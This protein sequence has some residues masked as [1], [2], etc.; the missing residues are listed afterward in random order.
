MVE[1]E[2]TLIH[3]GLLQPQPESQD[4]TQA[5]AVVVFLA[6]ELMEQAVQVAVEL[7]QL[8][9]LPLITALQTAVV[10]VVELI[11]Q[12]AGLP[13]MVVQELLLFAI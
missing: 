1:L 11:T 13:V 8:H 9:Y 5:V 3:H 10:V 7:L 4:F 2:V 12:A 6:P